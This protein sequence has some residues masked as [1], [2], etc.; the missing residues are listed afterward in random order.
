MTTVGYGDLLPESTLQ[1]LY[2]MLF[3]PIAAT[4]LAA[5]VERFDK[6]NASLRIHKTNFNLVVDSML[7][8]EAIAQKDILPT[9]SADAFVLRVLVDENVRIPFARFSH[10][11]NARSLPLL[12]LTDGRGVYTARA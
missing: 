9:L 1:K 7:K 5:T 3:M 4:T 12:C 10:V 2:T 6:L 11:S 8:E